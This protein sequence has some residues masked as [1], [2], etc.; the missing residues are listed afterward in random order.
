M[1]VMPKK[2]TIPISTPMSRETT[3]S[4]QNIIETD[5]VELK[6]MGFTV[7]RVTVPDHAF[8][9]YAFDRPDKPMH[10]W[11]LDLENAG[12]EVNHC[13]NRDSLGFSIRR[14]PAQGKGWT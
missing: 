6:G 8:P 12:F 7:T 9:S 13:L 10:E 1:T 4:E 14:K 11:R 2:K 5:L 3:E